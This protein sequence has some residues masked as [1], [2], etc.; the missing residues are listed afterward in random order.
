MSPRGPEFAPSSAPASPGLLAGL[1]PASFGIV[2]ATGIVSLACAS[3]GLPAV[4]RWL[5][6][7]NVL[8]Y[9]VVWGLT[10]A[11]LL[12]HPRRMRNDACDH[13]RAP[14]F[15][16]A[17][18][19]SGVLGG[20]C[21]LLADARGP[22]MW[23]EAVAV[24]LWVVLSYGIFAAV[25]VKRDKPRLEQGMSGGWLL[26][27]VATQALVGLGALLAPG[28]DAAW[29][30]RLALALLGLWLWGGVL[31]ALLMSLIFYRIMFL[32]LSP[33]DLSP[34][35]WINMGA[36]AI[37]TLAGTLLLQQSH[38]WPLLQTVQPFV[39]GVT[40]LFWAGGSWWIPLL[41]VLGVWRHGLQRHP[42]RYEGLYWAMVF[43]LGMYAMA[44]HHLALA[45]EQAWLEPLARAF[46]WVALGAWTLAALGLVG[47][48][49]QTLRRQ[50][51]PRARR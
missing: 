38:A 50:V 12:R 45:L 36:M 48:L 29:Q 46:M 32:P 39:Q 13:G 18:A 33:T 35:Y 26:A 37:S 31:Y 10:L 2:M 9:A 24:V 21:L 51:S 1:S 44:T 16:T 5:F 25:M 28:L 14:G 4:G 17:V 3:L 30:Q 6:A 47:A 22:A 19:A 27:V 7:L 34:P 20:Q 8:L 49:G 40:L 23:L 41:L 43:P 42:L 15:F 11:R